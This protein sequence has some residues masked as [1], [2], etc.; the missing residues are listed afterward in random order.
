MPA[1]PRRRKRRLA[2]MR[3]QDSPPRPNRQSDVALGCCRLAVS[4]PN[5]RW[6]LQSG[7]KRNSRTQPPTQWFH[8][9]DGW[10]WRDAPQDCYFRRSWP[11][12]AETEAKS[13]SQR[14][15]MARHSIA[16]RVRPSQ[17]VSSAD[18]LGPHFPVLRSCL[19]PL[20]NAPTRSR[21]DSSGG[22]L[23]GPAPIRDLGTLRGQIVACRRF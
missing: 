10:Q 12:E 19:R 15:E 4:V 13:R 21:M 7:E 1:I 17:R 2:N 6:L 16:A 8:Q 22:C 23:D 18:S 11:S 20:G 3:L 9:M 14:R 5:S